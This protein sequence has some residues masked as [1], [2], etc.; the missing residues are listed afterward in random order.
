MTQR[1]FYKKNP[2]HP[3][4]IRDINMKSAYKIYKVYMHITEKETTSKQ[5]EN[6]I[7]QAETISQRQVT[8]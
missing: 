3:H 5:K 1:I 7:I 6:Q 4:Q 8:S 2:V